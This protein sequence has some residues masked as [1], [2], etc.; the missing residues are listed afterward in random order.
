[1]SGVHGRIQNWVF[2]NQMPA[3]SSLSVRTVGAMSTLAQCDLDRV[4]L[5]GFATTMVS[6]VKLEASE[7]VLVEVA[8]TF[9]Q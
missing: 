4:F 7:K 1:M 5:V 2:V 8:A 6:L 3:R 9:G